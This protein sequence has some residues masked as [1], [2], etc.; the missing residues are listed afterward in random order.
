MTPK[1]YILSREHLNHASISRAIGWNKTSFSLWL[2]KG[3][4]IPD[5]KEQK[6]IELLKDYG[7]NA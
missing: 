1:Q 6:L 4:S 5:E 3:D 2:N 7:Y